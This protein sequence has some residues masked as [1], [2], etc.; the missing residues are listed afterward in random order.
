MISIHHEKITGFW[1]GRR[2]DH[3]PGVYVYLFRKGAAKTYLQSQH[4]LSQCAHNGSSSWAL[5]FAWTPWRLVYPGVVANMCI[6]QLPCGLGAH[7]DIPGP[8]ILLVNKHFP[9]LLS[10]SSLLPGA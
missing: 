1:G 7:L 9:V 6:M 4:A 3:A 8:L 10:F 2:A 5:G